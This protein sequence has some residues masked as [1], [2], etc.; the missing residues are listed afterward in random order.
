MFNIVVPPMFYSAV[1]IFFALF[2]VLFGALF[3]KKYKWQFALI[4]LGSVIA[5][6]VISVVLVRSLAPIVGRFVYTLAGTLPASFEIDDILSD[7][8][9]SLIDEYGVMLDYNSD[10]N[11]EKV[12]VYLTQDGTMWRRCIALVGSNI[13]YATYVTYLS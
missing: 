5:S 7:Y 13:E 1:Y 12:A 8:G 4:R 9:P 2:F 3:A 6:V 10:A 11:L